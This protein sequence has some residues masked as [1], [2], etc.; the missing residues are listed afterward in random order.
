MKFIYTC[1]VLNFG[2][3]IIPHPVIGDNIRSLSQYLR[4]Q[5]YELLVCLLDYWDARWVINTFEVGQTKSSQAYFRRAYELLACLLD[6]SI[7]KGLSFSPGLLQVS[8]AILLKL[9]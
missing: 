9:A 2:H 5:A 8:V 1:A 4:K 6:S 3:G 7:L